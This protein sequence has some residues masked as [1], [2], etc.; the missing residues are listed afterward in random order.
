VLV[1][2]TLNSTPLANAIATVSVGTGHRVV[3]GASAFNGQGELEV[4]PFAG[5]APGTYTYAV[6]FSDRWN[7]SPLFTVDINVVG[8]RHP[9]GTMYTRMNR[10]GLGGPAVSTSALD[11]RLGQYNPSGMTPVVLDDGTVL[12]PDYGGYQIVALS[13]DGRARRYAGSGVGDFPTIDGTP[14]LETQLPNP[15]GLAIHPT[16]GEVYVLTKWSSRQRI[17]RLANDGNVYLVAGGGSEILLDGVA[18][19][20]AQMTNVYGM[21]FVGD[22]IA[23]TE[24]TVSGYSAPRI[25][26]VDDQ[27]LIQTVPFQTGTCSNASFYALTDTGV[28]DH[29]Y[30]FWYTSSGSCSPQVGLYDVNLLDGSKTLKSPGTVGLQAGDSIVLSPIDGNPYYT[31][32]DRVIARIDGGGTE[33]ILVDATSGFDPSPQPVDGNEV[34]QSAYGLA[35][36]PDG[37]LVVVDGGDFGVKIITRPDT[38]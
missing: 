1:S 35:F 30:T 10:T 33:S 34:L 26:Y 19:E 20:T 11:S 24:N 6:S 12:V 32:H 16:T 5:D 4:F 8:E 7:G 28:A 13:P 22:R 31:R 23:Y 27:G 14:W 38:L 36:T 29:L 37:D 15:Y 18:A 3:A 9:D 17:Y 25:R 21:A 2:A